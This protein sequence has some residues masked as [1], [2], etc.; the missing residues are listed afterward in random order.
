MDKL[1]GLYIDLN[2]R[3]AS[4]NGNLLCCGLTRLNQPLNVKR[5]AV[6]P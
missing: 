4:G 1:K 2:G 3:H 6:W 5:Y